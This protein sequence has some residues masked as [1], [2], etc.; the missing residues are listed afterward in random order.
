MFMYIFAK[1]LFSRALRISL[2]LSAS[3]DKEN[4]TVEE[5][6]EILCDENPTA[7]KEIL[8]YLHKDWRTAFPSSPYRRTAVRKR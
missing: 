7:Q 2:S 1:T 6:T 3:Q 5:W 4:R 8:A